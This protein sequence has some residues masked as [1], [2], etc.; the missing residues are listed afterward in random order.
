MLYVFHSYPT[1]YAM[2]LTA[3]MGNLR[4]G[5]LTRLATQRAKQGNG[6]DQPG[7]LFIL[8]TPTKCS[9]KSSLLPSPVPFSHSISNFSLPTWRYSYSYLSENLWGG[10]AARQVYVLII[11]YAE[12]HKLRRH[13]IKYITNIP[14]Q[15]E[16]PTVEITMVTKEEFCNYKSVFTMKRKQMKILLVSLTSLHDETTTSWSS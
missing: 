10:F 5:K 1:V 16:L 2:V 7:R 9:H 11:C 13:G 14:K 8:C 12:L 3:G 6:T 4:Y 15:S